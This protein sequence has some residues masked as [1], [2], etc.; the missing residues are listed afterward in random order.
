V[1]MPHAQDNPVGRGVVAGVGATGLDRW[2]ER[3]D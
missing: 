2:P 1:L 3:G